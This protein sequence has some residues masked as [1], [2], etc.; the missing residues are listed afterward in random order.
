MYKIHDDFR[1]KKPHWKKIYPVDDNGD[2]MADNAELFWNE[3]PYGSSLWV[4]A[5]TEGYLT[6]D[7]PYDA[8]LPPIFDLW[9]YYETGNSTPTDYYNVTFSCSCNKTND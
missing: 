5:A 6:P 8:M 9:V 3:N 7:Q 2:S 1:N 4:L